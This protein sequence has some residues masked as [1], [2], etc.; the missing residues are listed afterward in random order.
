M[1]K[2]RKLLVKDTGCGRAECNV[3]RL[4]QRNN[5]EGVVKAEPTIHLDRPKDAADRGQRQLLQHV[6]AI[7]TRPSTQRPPLAAPR[8]AQA[9]RARHMAAAQPGGMHTTLARVG[10]CAGEARARARVTGRGG[11]VRGGGWRGGIAESKE[12]L[13][14]SKG[15]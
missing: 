7:A 6:R 14:K 13:M 1:S 15:N 5:E 4:Q 10:R 12:K 9:G 3:T 2:C 11:A 8:P